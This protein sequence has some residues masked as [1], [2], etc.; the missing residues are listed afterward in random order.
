MKPNHHVILTTIAMSSA[1]HE[2]LV[3][4]HAVYAERLATDP[5]DALTPTFFSYCTAL[6]LLCD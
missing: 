1:A 4:D 2:S 3:A 6:G 5:E